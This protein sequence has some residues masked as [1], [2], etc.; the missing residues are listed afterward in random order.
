MK[1]DVVGLPVTGFVVGRFVG[2]EASFLVGR[3]LGDDVV[4]FCIKLDADLSAK[5]LVSWLDMS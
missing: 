4:G 5:G 1:S 3:E 2:Q